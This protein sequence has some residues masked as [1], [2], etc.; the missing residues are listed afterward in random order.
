[1]ARSSLQYGGLE[2]L[3]GPGAL[4][5]VTTGGR[6]L[7]DPKTVVASLAAQ[8]TM[9]SAVVGRFT[10]N[11]HVKLDIIVIATSRT[12]LAAACDALAYQ[13]D[14]PTNTLT[15]NPLGGLVTVFDC[16]R[17][18]ITSS[19]NGTLERGFIRGMTIEF[20]ALPFGRSDTKTTI[21]GNSG[22][23]ALAN[24]STPSG[25]TYKTA[26]SSDG[27]LY[28]DLLAA[29][30]DP[31]QVPMPTTGTNHAAVTSS[32]P[33]F[34]GS[35]S[36]QVDANFYESKAAYSYTTI[37]E[38][39]SQSGG[40]GSSTVNVPAQGTGA[41]SITP[42]SGTWNLSA[43][44]NIVAAV[45]SA[46][47]SNQAVY[48]KLTDSHG[49]SVT[50][51]LTATAKAVGQWDQFKTNIAGTALDLANITA[52]TLTV[53][54]GYYNGYATGL[55]STPILLGEL[56][57]Y[58]QSSTQVSTTNGGSFKFANV[59]G[60]AQANA[61]LEMDRGGTNTMTGIMAYRAPTGSPNTTPIIVPMSGSP[62]TGATAAPTTLS[63]TYRLICA[64]SSFNPGTATLTV[65]QKVNGTTVASKTFNAGN[66]GTVKWFDFGEVT[67]PFVDVPSQATT[68]VTYTF[69]WSATIAGLT[70]TLLIDTRGFLVWVPSFTAAKYVWIDEATAANGLGG[71]YAGN[72][73]DRSD[74]TS[75]LGATGLA[76]AG[77]FSLDPGDN[78]L[79]VYCPDGLPN[80]TTSFYPRW[81]HE[82]SS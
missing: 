45:Y 20:D 32:P 59:P 5:N 22:T 69:A 66:P 17:G 23:V 71:V 14:Q 47:Y 16:W 60:S 31:S 46:T 61:T 51:T 1:M 58:P 28:P 21:S 55:P 24:F 41:I 77:A 78:Y 57:G 30:A 64:G 39:S 49:T 11:R 15:W 13:L 2:L 7:G 44:P 19:W 36:T 6:N 48:L 65:T 70:E 62:T 67:F 12:A 18:Q 81:L 26:S 9:G 73:P 75:L 56:R 53:A 10:D 63:G 68:N 54:V 4:Y 76:I 3:G 40:G 37:S 27:T 38:G 82:R 25:F 42:T 8:L 52:W 34:E 80:A 74:A 33:P 79:M 72:A 43:T 50:F 35:G 29:D